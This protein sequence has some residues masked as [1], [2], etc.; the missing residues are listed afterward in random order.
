MGDASMQLIFIEANSMVID[1]LKEN[2]RF[3]GVNMSQVEIINA[4]VCVD[5]TTNV[6]FFTWDS[7]LFIDYPLAADRTWYYQLSSTKKEVLVNAHMQSY[8]WGLAK[9]MDMKTYTRALHDSFLRYIIKVEV[10]CLSPSKLFEHVSA[11]R[12]DIAVVDLEGLDSQVVSA[13]LSYDEFR[14]AYLQFE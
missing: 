8:G 5:N 6:S 12:I 7:Q 13:L 11:D 1:R 10:P 14:P 3:H 9:G 2:L 4:A